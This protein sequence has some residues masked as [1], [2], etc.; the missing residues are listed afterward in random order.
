MDRR[1]DLPVLPFNEG[2]VHGTV[3]VV[4]GHDRLRLL[5]LALLDQEL[6]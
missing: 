6:A 5:V 4:L 3:R 2:V 1:A